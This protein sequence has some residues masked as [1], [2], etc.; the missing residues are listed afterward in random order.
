VPKAGEEKTETMEII[1]QRIKYNETATIGDLLI[2]GAPFCHTLEDKDRDLL[3]TMPLTDIAQKKIHGKTAIPKGKYEVALTFSNRF[4]KVMP[5]LLDVPGFAG[6]RIHAGN[7]SAD[8]EG[9]ILVGSKA[10][11][12]DFITESKK[13]YQTLLGVLTQVAHTE[14][15]FLTVV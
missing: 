1:L 4:Q 7:T 9:C 3:K 14:K 2:D 5:Q 13:T 11:G 6:I 10:T 15:I 8:T 12:D